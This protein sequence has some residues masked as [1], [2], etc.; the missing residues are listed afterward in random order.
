[1]QAEQFLGD[2]AI[3]RAPHQQVLGAEDLGGLGQHRRA[4]ELGQ[5][6]RAVAQRG[7]G[8]DAGER[9]RSAAI[10]AQDDLRSGALARAVPRRPAR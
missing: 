7:I 5:Q 2:F 1:M 10:Q 3:A 9:I 8:G 4:A 6:V